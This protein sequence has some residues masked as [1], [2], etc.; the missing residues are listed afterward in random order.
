[1]TSLT[2]LNI[3][4]VSG[5]SSLGTLH[6]SRGKNTPLMRSAQPLSLFSLYRG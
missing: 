5:T 6:T 4:Q 1:M 2:G 3:F